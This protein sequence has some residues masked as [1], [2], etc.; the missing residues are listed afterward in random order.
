VYSVIPK[1]LSGCRVF[2]RESGKGPAVADLVAQ[3]KQD[4]TLLT[5]YCLPGT[6]ADGVLQ[7]GSTG[8]PRV[9][10][11]AT[12]MRT[13]AHGGARVDVTQDLIILD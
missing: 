8:T 11:R 12:P 4:L 10:S 7:M 6:L 9:S 2:G 5:L 13:T 1:K 3:D